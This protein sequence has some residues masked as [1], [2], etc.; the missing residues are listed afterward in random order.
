MSLIFPL[1]A[2]VDAS[3]VL[4]RTLQL[5]EVLTDNSSAIFGISS[6]LD[7]Y[8]SSQKIPRFFSTLL[9]IG[10]GTSLALKFASAASKNLK[11]YLK[12]QKSWQTATLDTFR[13]SFTLLVAGGITFLGARLFFGI[14]SRL[15]KVPNSTLT[16]KRELI[17]YLF[18]PLIAL[19]GAI[20]TTYMDQWVQKKL[21]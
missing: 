16:P 14:E 7:G 4:K 6:A 8:Y 18:P 20:A 13:E 12:D 21:G 2:S 11:A 9:W 1:L 3:N 19:N 10:M 15:L 5:Q 17:P